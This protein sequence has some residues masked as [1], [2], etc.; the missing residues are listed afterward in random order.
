ME[1]LNLLSNVVYTFLNALSNVSSCC[2]N[3]ILVP[4]VGSHWIKI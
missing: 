4:V 2:A 1:L 3:L